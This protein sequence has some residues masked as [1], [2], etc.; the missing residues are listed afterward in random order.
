MDEVNPMDTSTTPPPLR[1][2]PAQE[3]ILAYRSGRMA[4]SL[5]LI[6]I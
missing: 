6:H 3:E 4:V 5:S 2:R 1:L